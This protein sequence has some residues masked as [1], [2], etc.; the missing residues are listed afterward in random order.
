[1]ILICIPKSSG[2]PSPKELQPLPLSISWIC[3]SFILFIVVHVFLLMICVHAAL[4]CC[5]C[6]VMVI[7]VYAVLCCCSCVVTGDLCARCSLETSSLIQGLVFS[8][9][10]F[11]VVGLQ[12]LARRSSGFVLRLDVWKTN[13]VTSR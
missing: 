7:C 13:R 12:A 2:T 1:M 6:V 8:A 11:L 3:L 4:C 10:A 5:S 9:L